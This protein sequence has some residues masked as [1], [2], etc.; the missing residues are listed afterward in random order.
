L[1]ELV[2]REPRVVLRAIQKSRER[3]LGAP[4]A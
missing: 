2:D 4:A 1:L 3:S